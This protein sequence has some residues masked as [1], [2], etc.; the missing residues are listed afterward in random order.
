MDVPRSKVGR[1]ALFFASELFAFF[2]ISVNNLAL[3]KGYYLWT[4]ATDMILVFQGMLISKL[5]IEDAKSRDWWSIFGFT[6]G[7]ATGSALAIFA[8][9]HLWR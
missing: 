6:F 8:T 9:K 3:N 4:S 5:M 7:G 1:F 2:V